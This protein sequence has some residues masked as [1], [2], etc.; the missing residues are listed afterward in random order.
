MK[1]IDQ[2]AITL[3]LPLQQAQQQQLQ[4]RNQFPYTLLNNYHEDGTARGLGS[5]CMFLFIL[6]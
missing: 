3:P 5:F 6:F 4:G 1:H 2:T